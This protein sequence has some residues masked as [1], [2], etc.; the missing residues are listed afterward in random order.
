MKKLLSTML[1][2]LVTLSVAAG[3][4][5]VDELLERIDKGASAKFKTELV[6]S[7]KEVQ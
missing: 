3:K 7:Q 5:P 2:A 1:L 6:K 4:N